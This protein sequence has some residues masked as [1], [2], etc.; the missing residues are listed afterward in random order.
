LAGGPFP[1]TLCFR[2]GR[3][4]VSFGGSGV[5]APGAQQEAMA[6]EVGPPRHRTVLCVTARSLADEREDELVLNL[7]LTD[8][9]L[10]A[11]GSFPV[12]HWHSHSLQRQSLQAEFRP[13]TEL[14]LH[15]WSD[16]D[17]TRIRLLPGR[18]PSRGD[19]LSVVSA[20]RR[21]VFLLVVT[22]VSEA[23]PQPDGR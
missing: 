19:T 22:D 7:P 4:T 9:A 14:L 20:M 1:L 18:Q 5:R 12:S 11:T 6:E 3:C 10:D 23:A 15:T 17:G 13:Q 2:V 21:S 8:G 16:G